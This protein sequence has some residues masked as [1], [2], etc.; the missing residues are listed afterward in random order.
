MISHCGLLGC[1]GLLD[2]GTSLIVGSPDQINPIL[3]ALQISEDCSNYDNGPV[4]TIRIGDEKY[5]IPSNVY[6]LREGNVCAPGLQAAQGM[7]F[8][9]FGDTF[10][11]TVYAVFDNDN[12]RAGLA[13]QK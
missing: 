1:Q 2:T 8:M 6:T 5:D 9:I 7:P 4:L 3:D 10:L 13:P 12:Y 11:R